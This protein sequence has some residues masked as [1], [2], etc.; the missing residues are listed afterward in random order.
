M[1][2]PTRQGTCCTGEEEEKAA[3]ECACAICDGYWAKN[4]VL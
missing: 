4:V 1:L 3:L 2:H